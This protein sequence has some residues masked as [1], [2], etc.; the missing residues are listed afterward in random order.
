MRSAPARR[1]PEPEPARVLSPR[2]R[3]AL[4]ASGL[5]DEAF[6]ARLARWLRHARLS[7]ADIDALKV[8]QSFLACAATRRLDR[9]QARSYL[10]ALLGIGAQALED[11]AA[12]AAVARQD[13]L[14]R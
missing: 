12:R 8:E 6:R 14:L 2:A 11:Y 3:R 5:L 4:A 7:D 13:H 9:P 1:A 10:A